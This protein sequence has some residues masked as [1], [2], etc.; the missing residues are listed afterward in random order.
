MTPR[1]IT[2]TRKIVQFVSF[3]LILYGALLGIRVETP[4]IPF[5]RAPEGFTSEE[6]IALMR[7][8][9][10]GQV[11]D[12]YI[13]IKTCR[14]AR[15]GGLFRACFMHF[16][17]EAITWRTPWKDFLPHL[18]IFLLLAVMLG[19]FWCGWVCP[20]GFIQDTLASLRIKLGLNR[21]SLSKI[22]QEFLK[23][24]KWVLIG[25]ILF[26]SLLIAFPQLPWWIRK[27]LFIVGCQLCPSRFIIPYI[28]GHPI[29][30]SLFSPLLIIFFSIAMVFMAVLIMSAFTKRSF[31]RFCPNGVLL[32]FFNR[33]GLLAKEKNLNRCT[34]CG[35]CI[36]SCPLE[37]ENVYQEKKKRNVDS[38]DC[39]RC[40][41]CVDS[42]PED[43]ALSVKFLGLKAWKS[44][45]KR[46]K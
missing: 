32:S 40:F 18:V 38:P 14:F 45:F 36:N 23:K 44:K 31:C 3:F 10:H 12:T 7:G 39:I 5:I 9:K 46:S 34:R 28:T 2:L 43:G 27:E 20:L 6:R 35:I 41:R 21:L 19:T 13:G 37:N 29:E 4:L 16:F 33:G 22:W 25:F 30:Q 42:C 15:G 17:S 8:P 24:F 26:V 11:F 1:P